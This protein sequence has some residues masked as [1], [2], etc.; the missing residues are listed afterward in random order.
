MDVSTYFK[1]EQKV[2]VYQVRFDGNSKITFY[3][4]VALV[5]YA[6]CGNYRILLPRFFRKN[7]VK[8]TRYER[9]LL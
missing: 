1:I 8:L 9:T 4:I 7:S 2:Q 5:I 6:H 3:L